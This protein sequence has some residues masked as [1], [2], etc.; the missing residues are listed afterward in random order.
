LIY[1]DDSYEQA[2]FG[3]ESLASWMAYL[4]RVMVLPISIGD[5][6]CKWNAKYG[7]SSGRGELVDF[8]KSER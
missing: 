8:I 4:T 1:L 6:N 3:N 5:V 2:A 7:L